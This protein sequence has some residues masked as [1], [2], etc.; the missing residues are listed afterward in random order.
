MLG[1]PGRTVFRDPRE[2]GAWSV[3]WARRGT[4]GGAASG[5]G[6]A[7]R[8]RWESPAHPATSEPLECRELQ[9]W[10]GPAAQL[11]FRDRRASPAPLDLL[12]ATSGCRTTCTLPQPE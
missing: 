1:R 2:N 11:G 9:A 7:S 6:T 5:E 4:R 12:G 3:P 8:A 10:M